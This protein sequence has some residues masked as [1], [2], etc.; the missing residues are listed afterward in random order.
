M[1]TLPDAAD[2]APERPPD[3]AIVQHRLAAHGAVLITCVHG[4][5]RYFVLSQKG[6]DGLATDDW[7]DIIDRLAKVN[8]L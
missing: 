3:F 4:A 1:I 2:S 7:S 6:M 8:E 5:Q